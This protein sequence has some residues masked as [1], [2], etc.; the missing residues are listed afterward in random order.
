MFLE[1]IKVS[2]ITPSF[3]DGLFIKETIQSIL[4]QTHKNIEVIIVDDCSTDNTSAIIKSFQDPRIKVIRNAKNEGAAYSRNLAITLATGDYIAFLD[5]DDLWEKEKL[6]KQLQFMQAND[7]LFTY[8]KYSFISDKSNQ[9][10]GG[11]SKVTHKDF[12]RRNYVG[13]LTVMYKK[14]LFPDLQIPNDI[15]KRNDYALWLKL[16]ERADCYL[17]DELLAKYRKGKLNSVSSEKKGKLFKFHRIMFQKLYGFGYFKAMMF[18]LRNALYY[19]FRK[20][21][22]I[23]KK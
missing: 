5:G 20:G 21:K 10:V 23:E 7:Y 1:E 15:Y 2:V 18:S 11:P 12:L 16:S 3:N 14:S 4:N 13:C 8:T 9:I 17:L 19:L 6:T 22:Y